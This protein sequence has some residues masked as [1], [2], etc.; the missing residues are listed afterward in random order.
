MTE[1]KTRVKTVENV[2]IIIISE[3]RYTV[4]R[5]IYSSIIV[6]GVVVLRPQQCQNSASHGGVVVSS[7]CVV[8]SEHSLIKQLK[9]STYN[10]FLL[11]YSCWYI[12]Q[13]HIHVLLTD[14]FSAK[15]TSIKVSY[16]LP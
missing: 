4:T 14:A 12:T 1:R 2:R 16:D 10:T 3:A 5:I 15:L 9:N 6:S 13:K 8:S 7:G 11:C